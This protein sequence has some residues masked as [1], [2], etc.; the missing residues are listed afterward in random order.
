M[1]H[2]EIKERLWVE[3]M[4]DYVITAELGHLAKDQAAHKAEMRAH[5]DKLVDWLTTYRAQVLEEVGREVVKME[6][7]TDGGDDFCE[8]KRIGYN[9][10]LDRVL[11]YLSHQHPT[12]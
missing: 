4:E 5:L 2:E 12:N 10:A 3:V 7:H 9:L 8:G 6:N 11:L 1:T